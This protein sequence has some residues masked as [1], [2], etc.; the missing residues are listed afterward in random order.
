MASRR[1]IRRRIRSIGSTAQI[2][3]AM[4]MVAA[5]KMRKAQEAALAGRPFVRPPVPDPARG[6]AGRRRWSTRS[7]RCARSAGGR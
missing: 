1:E 3:R 4:Q 2:T 6:H 7:W 5:S